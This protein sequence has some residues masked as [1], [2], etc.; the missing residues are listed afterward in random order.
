MTVTTKYELAR[1]ELSIDELEAVTG[2][3]LWGWIKHEASDALHWIERHAGSAASVIEKVL[4][5][6]TY[7]PHPPHRMS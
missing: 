4:G 1:A 5:G 3:G 6:P 7:D 2:G